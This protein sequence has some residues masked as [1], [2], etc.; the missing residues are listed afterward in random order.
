MR[1]GGGGERGVEGSYGELDGRGLGGVRLS[2]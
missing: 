1:E 2:F